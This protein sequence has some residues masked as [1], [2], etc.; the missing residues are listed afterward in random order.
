MSNYYSENLKGYT[1]VKFPV[2]NSRVVHE[3]LREHFEDNDIHEPFN[4]RRWITVGPSEYIYFR[5]R[6][7]AVWFKLRW[8]K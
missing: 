4:Q 6:E 7:D 2:Y 8:N 1:R 5:D 3:F